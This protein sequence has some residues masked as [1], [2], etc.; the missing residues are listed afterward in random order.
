MPILT[1]SDRRVPT[2]GP[3]NYRRVVIYAD[4]ILKGI[5]PNELSAQAPVKFDMVVN[6]KTAT[7]IG[8]EMPQSFY[9]LANEAIEWGISQRTKFGPPTTGW[10][11]GRSSSAD[12]RHGSSTPDSCRIVGAQRPTESGQQR[13]SGESIHPQ[14]FRPPSWA[15]QNGKWCRS[16]CQN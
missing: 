14:S 11:Q 6:A 16:C 4:R 10:G 8:L 12:R 2:H 9:W 7:A 5:K 13:K 3:D 1:M 15:V